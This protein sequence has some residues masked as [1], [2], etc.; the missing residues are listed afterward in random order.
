MTGL[1]LA[2]PLSTL[3]TCDPLDPGWS[4]AGSSH[5]HLGTR[6]CSYEAR[7]GRHTAGP[8]RSFV[9]DEDQ[10]FARCVAG[11]KGIYW[12]LMLPR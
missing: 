4:F 12:E 2:N 9:L 6:G 5:G 7:S 3:L 10:S 1:N 11:E 8:A